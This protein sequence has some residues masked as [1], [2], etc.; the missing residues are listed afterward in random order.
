MIVVLFVAFFA[1]SIITTF[2]KGKLNWNY[3]L[4][5]EASQ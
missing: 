5:Q 3:N 1:T 2:N 4:V